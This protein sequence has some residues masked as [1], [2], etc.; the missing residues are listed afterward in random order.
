MLVER[1]PDGVLA[2]KVVRLCGFT[3]RT[4][5][6]ERAREG[7]GASVIVVLTFEE[8]WLIDGQRHTSFIAGL[9]EQQVTTEHPGRSF[10]MQLDLN[11][12]AARSLVGGPLHE[13]AN[14]SVPLEDV[15]AE[16]F[17]VERLAIAHGWDARFALLE[18]VLSR[19]LVDAKPPEE[20]SWAW[21]RLQESQ[22]RV[23]VGALATELGWSR[24]RIVERFRDGLGLPPKTLARL[25][26][27]EHARALAG[28]MPWAEV[29]YECGF[30]DQSHLIAEFRRITGRTPETFLQDATA[31]A[32]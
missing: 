9:H 29:A 31:Q 18:D 2:G 10:G 7:P 24:R 11:P 6:P 25:L 15:L 3:Q 1:R 19:R 5:A 8:H 28:T 13:F 23:R 27:F 12:L 21:R 20:L 22:G 30:A 32:A 26:R 14:R 4:P 16:P 17:L